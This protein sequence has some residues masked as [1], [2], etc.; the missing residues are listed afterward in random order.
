MTSSSIAEPSIQGV[1]FFVN[2]GSF[3]D[4]GACFWSDPPSKTLPL[5]GAGAVMGGGST[6]GR[7]DR[8]KRRWLLLP[9]AECRVLAT[10][11]GGPRACLRSDAL[12]SPS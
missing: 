7:G 11:E 12:L 8:A 3:G 6:T 10:P 9:C 4:T 2:S 1:L 5:R